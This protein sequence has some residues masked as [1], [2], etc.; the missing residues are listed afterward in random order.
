MHLFRYG[1]IKRDANLAQELM[2]WSVIPDAIPRKGHV[3][4]HGSRVLKMK[5]EFR[6]SMKGFCLSYIIMAKSLFQ[7]HVVFLIGHF[8]E[9]CGFTIISY[10]V[11]RLGRLEHLSIIL[12]STMHFNIVPD[13]TVSRT[14]KARINDSLWS[15]LF[16]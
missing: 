2:V 1:S 13:S 15:S 16:S 12:F 5:P 4:K 6:R 7:I 10:R 9:G 11:R 14:L 3:N 8:S